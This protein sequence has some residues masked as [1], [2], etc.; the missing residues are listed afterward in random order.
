MSRSASLDGKPVAATRRDGAAVLGLRIRPAV[1]RGVAI[2][3]AL[4]ALLE[5]AGRAGWVPGYLMPMPSD[6]LLTLL[7]LAEGP[8][9]KHIIASSLRVAAGFGI[10]TLL[11]LVFGAWVGLSTL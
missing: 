9:W 4:L 5:I 8:L 10:G 11:A 7:E 2:P 1:L 6:L 3:L